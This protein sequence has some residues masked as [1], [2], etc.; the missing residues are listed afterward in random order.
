M[1]MALSLQKTTFAAITE[2]C[3]NAEKTYRLILSKYLT[4]LRQ[5]HTKDIVSGRHMHTLPVCVC[6][7][8]MMY[9]LPACLLASVCVCVDTMMYTL[10]ACLCVCVCV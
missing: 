7:D 8:T 10:P 6:V 4:L 5:A 9:T 3:Y 2:S 1:C